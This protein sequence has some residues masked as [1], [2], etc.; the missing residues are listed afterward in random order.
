MS[1]G[2]NASSHRKGTTVMELDW[3]IT[4]L[5]DGEGCFMVSFN[6]RSGLNTGIEVRPSFSVSQN[7]RNLEVIKTLQKFFNCGGIRFDKHDQTY[8]FEVRSIDD[9]MKKVIPHFEKF[10]LKTTKSADFRIFQEICQAVNKNFHRS[11][12]YLPDIIKKAYGMNASGRG[13]YTQDFLLKRL[14]EMKR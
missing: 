3:Y 4:G 7:K 12:K 8:K 13:K 14:N 10:P 5:V 9:L 6:L 11:N 2:E 1:I